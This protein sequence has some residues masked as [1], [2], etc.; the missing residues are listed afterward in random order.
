MYSTVKD[1]HVHYSL[2]KCKLNHNDITI[3]PTL[4]WLK[5]K[6][7]DDIKSC[8]GWGVIRGRGLRG[9][10]IKRVSHKD[11]FYSTGNTANI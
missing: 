8:Q 7:P 5:P 10:N 3:I 1:T 2:Q 9:I 4:T 11:I 6:K